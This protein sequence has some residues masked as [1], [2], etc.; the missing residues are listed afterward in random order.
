MTH[1][2]RATKRVAHGGVI[3]AAGET[4]TVKSD[5]TRDHLVKTGAAEEVKT[6]K[7]RATTTEKPKT[8]GKKSATKSKAA[9][10]KTDG[11]ASSRETQ[12]AA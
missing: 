2:M 4:F 5:D 11:K 10:P 1:K 7:T 12:P 9:K 8:D 3:V 6:S